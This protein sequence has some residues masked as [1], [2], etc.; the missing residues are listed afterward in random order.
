MMNKKKYEQ[1]RTV[2]AVDGNESR[3]ILNTSEWIE[4]LNNSQG[5][6]VLVRV[7]I[8]GLATLYCSQGRE[9][10]ENWEFCLIVIF[11]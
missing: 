2:L 10:N 9:Y 1:K 4:G 7:R 8:V 11:G 6:K 5:L 3:L